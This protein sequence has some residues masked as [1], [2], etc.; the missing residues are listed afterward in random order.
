MNTLADELKEQEYLGYWWL[1]VKDG[2]QQV[3]RAGVI[4]FAPNNRAE[5]H[6]LGSFEDIPIALKHPLLKYPVIQGAAHGQKR[7]TLFDCTT[8][9]SNIDLFESA[10]LADVRITFIEGWVGQETYSSK[11]E[12]QF[13][14]FRA[15][16]HGLAAWH[17]V[18]AFESR[19]DW[20]NKHTELQYNCPK[21]VE[22]FKD[23]LVEIKLEYSW[24]PA[25]Q[26]L[27]QCEGKISH[28]PRILIKSLNGKLPY[29]GESNSYHFYLNRIRSVLGL[30]VGRGCPLYDCSGLVQKGSRRKDE[31]VVP[32]IA[33]QHLWRRDIED[34]KPIS[35]CDVWLPY[36]Y[37]AES[38]KTVVAGF[39]SMD[40]FPAGLAGHLVYL[41]ASRRT[42]FTQGALPELVY[43]FEGL[44]KQL[45]CK[46]LGRSKQEKIFL[47]NR[48]EDE[49]SRIGNV[50][51]F[52]DATAKD[53]L[54]KYV[55][56]RRV[57]FSHANPDSFQDNIPLYI[58][59][60]IWMRM[61]LMAM[62]LKYCGVPANV[63]YAALSK[64]NEYGHIAKH[65]PLLLQNES[66]Q[67]YPP[68]TQ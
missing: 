63:L 39:M 58:N 9:N 37:V 47:A 41:N 30:M 35:P 6:L 8:Y 65:M 17:N 68:V 13:L 23:E 34:D 56:D 28:D 64:N 19:N 12:I 22:L 49:F 59:V 33:L 14:D 21:S 45:Y 53:S 40:E 57:A 67:S 52:I 25:S 3:N 60:T 31:C 48:F 55:K 51:P 66:Q 43:M 42:N 10:E 29:Y 16:M 18:K 20:A 15:G 36:E 54:I 61:F 24:Q 5:L 62:V 46:E 44:H 27:A 1:P 4:H 11:S 50:F 32:E 2:Q 38:L 7:I 26:Q